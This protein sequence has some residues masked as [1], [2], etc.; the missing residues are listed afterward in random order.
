MSLSDSTR[1]KDMIDKLDTYRLRGV[2]EYWLVD[3]KQINILVYGLDNFEIDN[4]MIFETEE[5]ARSFEFSGLTADI[6][7]LFSDLI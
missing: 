7:R 5:A 2:R 1:S 4:D 3:Y 6:D